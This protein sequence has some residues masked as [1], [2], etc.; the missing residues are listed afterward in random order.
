M[1]DAPKR[2]Q[3]RRSKGW[4]APEG[5]VYVG[6]PGRFGN[7]FFQWMGKGDD[8]FGAAYEARLFASWLNGSLTDDMLFDKLAGH[9]QPAY[10]RLK[11][12][13]LAKRK[14]TIMAGLPA[15]RGKTLMCWCPAGSPCH[16]DV[17]LELANAPVAAREAQGEGS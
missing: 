11:I 17:L 14:A 5:A 7:P 6:R 13:R 1:S 16:A 12:D 9:K 4:K 8:E 15:L 10:A 2:I 3:R